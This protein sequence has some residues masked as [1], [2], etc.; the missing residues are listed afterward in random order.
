MVQ[1]SKGGK[2]CRSSLA[3]KKSKGG[4]KHVRKNNYKKKKQITLECSVCMEEIDDTR[5]NVITCG[6]VNHPLCGDCKLKCKECPMCRSHSVKP[7]ISQEVKMKVLSSSS[8]IEN[9][10]P[11][12]QIKVV[13]IAI[14]E[15]FNFASDKSVW[16]G[17]YYLFRKNSHNYPRKIYYQ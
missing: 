5:D 4:M 17:I 15:V 12:Q 10:S 8:K 3:G 16:N 14:G 6:K 13:V 9:E 2:K 7:P 11:K 1:K